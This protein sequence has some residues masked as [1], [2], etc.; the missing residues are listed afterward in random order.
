[1]YCRVRV[2]ILL[3]SVGYCRVRVGILLDSVGYCRVRVGILLDSVGYFSSFVTNMQ[4]IF[5]A[6]VSAG[7]YFWLSRFRHSSECVL[8]S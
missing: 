5:T 4:H 3:D 7:V 8:Y 2:G 1:M 6:G